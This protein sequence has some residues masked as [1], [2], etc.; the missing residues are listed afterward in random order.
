MSGRF[1]FDTQPNPVI[2]A[3]EELS[4]ADTTGTLFG[5]RPNNQVP[6][7]DAG[8]SEG[9]NSGLD[10]D[11]M[12]NDAFRTTSF[13]SR[14]GLGGE[15]DGRGIP[16]A[17]AAASRDFR[18][19]GL[20]QLAAVFDVLSRLESSGELK[21]LSREV[22]EERQELEAQLAQR[23]DLEHKLQKTRSDVDDLRQQH[24]KVEIGSLVAQRKISHLQDEL[25]S[26]QV[27]ARQAEDDLAALREESGHG[28]RAGLANF[29]SPYTSAEK[30][31][32]D[33]LTKA[34]AER[35][36]LHTDQRSIQELRSRLE[37]IFALKKE[38]QI[39]QQALLEKQRQAEQDRGLMLTAI[40]AERGKL[41]KLRAERIKL[42]E[43]RGGLE[44]DI[45]AITQRE[46][47]ANSELRAAMAPKYTSAADIQRG[48]PA[49][50]LKP[51][52]TAQ[53]SKGW[54]LDPMFQ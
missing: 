46:L 32:R 26:L 47:A 11:L 41:S 29:G 3:A 2:R 49:T 28:P 8:R 52:I 30:E 25:A 27:E 23:R 54:K 18:P 36:F 6:G 37:D 34:R 7:T 51:P 5:T 42:C 16:S 12:A 39:Q 40:E 50:G 4:T 33:I 35:E 45:A 19:A 53:D 44:H 1:N 10:L 20:G 17:A 31:R 24:R 21:R 48:V 15:S 43:E 13:P 14:S 9:W 38:A 22:L